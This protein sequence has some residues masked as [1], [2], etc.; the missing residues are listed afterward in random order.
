M[1]VD[2]SAHY[3]DTEHMTALDMMTATEKLVN[4]YVVSVNIFK[5][6]NSS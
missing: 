6:Y 2:V 4:T 5:F 3:T 1:A